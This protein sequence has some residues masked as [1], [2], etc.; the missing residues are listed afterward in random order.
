VLCSVILASC[1]GNDLSQHDYFSPYVNRD[2]ILYSDARLC[3]TEKF[4]FRDITL[5]SA[6]QPCEPYIGTLVR[7]L[8]AGE[9]IRI[10]KVLEPI[11]YNQVGIYALGEVAG[12]RFE[13]AWGSRHLPLFLAPWEPGEY[14][15]TRCLGTVW[16]RCKDDDSE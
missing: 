11:G 6:N 4:K 5:I 3:K 16:T 2:L 14:D 7:D 1:A 9:L 13:Y 15:R 10:T 8:Q 12:F